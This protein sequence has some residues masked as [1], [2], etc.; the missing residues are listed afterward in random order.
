[1]QTLELVH[2]RT[3]PQTPR[4][5]TLLNVWA[6]VPKLAG[7]PA[8]TV[9]DY[10]QTI[11]LGSCRTDG[12]VPTMTTSAQMFAMADGVKLK[13]YHIAALFGHRPEELRGLE[14]VSEAQMEAMLGDSIHLAAVGGILMAG[15]A[16]IFGGLSPHA[17]D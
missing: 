15:L 16:A 2:G 3:G 13:W 17:E 4:V 6:R 1:M 14:Y 5:R 12:L 9:I 10:S 7:L 11:G 8:C